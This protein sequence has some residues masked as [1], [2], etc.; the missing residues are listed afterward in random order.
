MGE[1][2]KRRRK[3]IARRPL[4]PKTIRNCHGLLHVIL[5]AAIQ[6]RLSAPTRARSPRRASPAPAEYEMRFLTDEEIGRL[7]EAIPA[8]WRPLVILLVATVRCGV[9]RSGLRVGRVNLRGGRPSLRGG[10]AV[11]GDVEHR[12][13]CSARRRRNGPAD[14]RFTAAATVLAPLVAPER[15]DSTWS[16]S[17]RAVQRCTRNF[18]RMWLKA[19]AAAELPGLRIHDLQHTHVAVLIA[20]GEP[21]DVGDPPA[22]PRL[23]RDNRCDLRPP[24]RGGR[25]RGSWRLPT[26][27]SP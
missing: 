27:R 18:R 5:G 22:R 6:R 24:A 20:R 1:D 9:R 26:C 23:D 7:I 15:P 13:R 10:G 17:R 25:R 8:Y 11:A 14:G 12:Q 16:F 4:A 21:A 3:P 2:A 19:T